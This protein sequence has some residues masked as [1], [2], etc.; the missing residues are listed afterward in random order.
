MD[1]RPN[2]SSVEE[3]IMYDK[4]V[5]LCPRLKALCMDA[6]LGASNQWD[7][8]YLAVMDGQFYNMGEALNALANEMEKYL[9]CNP[10]V[11]RRQLTGP[12]RRGTL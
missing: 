5:Q 1:E 4:M 6:P 8:L 11:V 3:M 9:R 12:R 2:Y 7:E 10:P